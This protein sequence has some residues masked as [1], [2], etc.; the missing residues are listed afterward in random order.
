[1][2]ADAA[3]VGEPGGEAVDAA[4]D[5]AAWQALRIYENVN[6]G[7][8][9]S[10]ADAWQMLSMLAVYR[11][12]LA[13]SETY[14]RRSVEIRTAAYGADDPRLAYAVDMLGGALRRLGRYD[15]GDRH[16]R[17]SITLYEHDKGPNDVGLVVPLTIDQPESD[18]SA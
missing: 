7:S 12:D 14:A 6:G 10:T 17:R 16:M 1:M 11:S 13:A 2:Q 8:D 5:S 4:A 15:E 9:P 3:S 18:R